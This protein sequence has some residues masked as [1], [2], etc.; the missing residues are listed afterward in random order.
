[1][2]NGQDAVLSS[3]GVP[4]ALLGFQHVDAA[5]RREALRQF[6]HTT[7]QPLARTIEA[8]FASAGTSFA[9]DFKAVHAADIQ[10]RARAFM[11][12]VKSGVDIDEAWEIAGFDT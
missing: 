7:L 5:G 11:Q 3:C 9:L 10:S 2:I 12:L 6:L 4:S 8:E 1:M